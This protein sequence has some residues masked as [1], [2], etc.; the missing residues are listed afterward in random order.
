MRYGEVIRHT[1]DARAGADGWYHYDGRVWNESTSRVVQMQLETAR[2]YQDAASDL[3]ETTPDE[4]AIRK[5]HLRN[6]KTMAQERGMSSARKLAATFPEIEIS[7][8]ELDA[9]PWAFAAANGVI[10]LRTGELREHHSSDLITRMS[11]VSYDPDATH[12]LWDTFL[13]WLTKGR[14]D[15]K[16]FLKQAAG[17]TLTGDTREE[18]LFFLHGPAQSGKTTLVESLKVVMGSY[19]LTADFSTFLKGHNVGGPRPDIARL[20]G[21]RYVP[22]IEVDQGKSLAEGLV[23]QMTGGDT[24]TARFLYGAEFEYQATHKLWLVAN[25]APKVN[26]EDTGLWRRILRVPCDNVVP[27]ADRDPTVKLRLK[28][29]IE[30]GPAILAWAVEGCLDWQAN[31]LVVPE[32]IMAATTEYRES[33]D[34]ITD[35]LSEACEQGPE[36]RVEFGDLLSAYHQY[37]K[38]YHKKV[39]GRNQFGDR[40]EAKGFERKRS[41]GKR[42]ITGLTLAAS[43][44]S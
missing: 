27:E 31:G 3:P 8:T 29:P 9:D 41:N 42:F 40:L 26:S 43:D 38:L 2:A 35:F 10:D 13:D 7:R 21:A 23:K 20:S 4:R 25:D 1:A 6:A 37:C 36:L 30:C 39:L 11:P 34:P 22:S 28:D 44:F 32:T 33:Q 17:Y 18:R 16:A 15:L 12:P 14:A 5:A 24:I 19:S